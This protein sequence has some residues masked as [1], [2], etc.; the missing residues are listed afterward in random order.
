MSIRDLNIRVIYVEEHTRR[1]LTF[2]FIYEVNMKVS[3]MNVIYVTTR[4]QR[5]E[6]L[7]N[8]KNQN[9]RELDTLVESVI[10]KPHRLDI[11]NTIMN[12]P[13]ISMSP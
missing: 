11:L 4:I 2:K 7:S 12:D 6:S 8:I 13:Y 3:F 9:M 5:L 1:N 10:L